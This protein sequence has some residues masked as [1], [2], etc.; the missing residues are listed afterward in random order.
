[1][2]DETDSVEPWT[3]ERVQ[4]WVHCMGTTPAWEVD[5]AQWKE[6]VRQ[7]IAFLARRGDEH[8]RELEGLAAMQERQAAMISM[9]LE[10]NDL[11]RAKLL[12]VTREDK[13]GLG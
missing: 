13:D 3:L 9:L 12:L 8:E 2:A 11:L 4:A 7:V 5:A 10:E 6:A 1:M